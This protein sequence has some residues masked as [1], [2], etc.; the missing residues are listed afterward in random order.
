LALGGPPA[1]ESSPALAERLPI[2]SEE[3]TALQR[4]GDDGTHPYKSNHIKS[5]WQALVQQVLERIE[6]D[7]SGRNSWLTS[8]HHSCLGAHSSRRGCFRFCSVNGLSMAF[9]ILF[10]TV[11]D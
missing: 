3:R 4:H 2:D 1:H 6:S 5:Y 7:M 10:E 8:S 9:W 11:L